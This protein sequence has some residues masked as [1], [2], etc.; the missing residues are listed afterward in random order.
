MWQKLNYI[1]K[2]IF[3][4]KIRTLLVNLKFL[5]PS[6]PIRTCPC[7]HIPGGNYYLWVCYVCPKTLKNRDTSIPL[8]IYKPT[9]NI[10]YCVWGRG[11]FLQRWH[12]VSHMV[13]QLA[14]F[15]FFLP[16]STFGEF[17]HWNTYSWFVPLVPG[18]P[19]KGATLDQPFFP[20][21]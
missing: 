18:I 10:L 12:H 8:F 21:W 14:F 9:Q 19:L 5:C 11:V 7:L 20:W 3:F 16:H 15:F 4:K 6:L 1:C 2:L 13:W 17:S